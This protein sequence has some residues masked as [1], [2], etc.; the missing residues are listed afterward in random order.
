MPYVW[1]ICYFYLGTLGGE[2][3][4]QDSNGGYHVEPNFC[5]SCMPKEIS[6]TW[7]VVPVEGAPVA[8]RLNKL[9]REVT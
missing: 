9:L 1:P 4:Y 7:K 2:E 3:F 5:D 8:R 6:S